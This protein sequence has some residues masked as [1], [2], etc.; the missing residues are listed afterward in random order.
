MVAP[1]RS[2]SRTRRPLG[3]RLPIGS[4]APTDPFLEL[5]VDVG[6][7]RSDIVGRLV[8]SAVGNRHADDEGASFQF[9]SLHITTKPRAAVVAYN[10]RAGRTPAT[11]EAVPG[12]LRVFVPR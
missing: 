7:S 9:H 11:V 6:V 2:C 5:N 8:A 3:L 4:A 12:A 1:A 10:E